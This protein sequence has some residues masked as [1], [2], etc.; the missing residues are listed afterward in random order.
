VTR[1]A[2]KKRS[3]RLEP[4]D[5]LQTRMEYYNGLARAEIKKGELGS[6]EK[7]DEYLK[8][9]QDA[10]KEWGPYRHGRAQAGEDDQPKK[11]Y[12]V[13]L[14][15]E[16]EFENWAEWQLYYKVVE[17]KADTE[18]IAT[19]GESLNAKMKALLEKFRPAAKPN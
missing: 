4:A 8:L 2:A 7:I 13:R 17:A 10:A 12:V 18:A 14:G 1:K 3:Q 11:H 5:V 16:P 9:A 15:G 6:R 19:G